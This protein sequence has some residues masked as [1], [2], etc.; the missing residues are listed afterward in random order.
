MRSNT[1]TSQ[2]SRTRTQTR[3][4]N[5]SQSRYRTPIA[6]AILNDQRVAKSQLRL[7]GYVQ[8]MFHFE[9]NKIK[10]CIIH[11]IESK[12]DKLQDL[13]EFQF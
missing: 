1:T 13:P 7:N 3:Y 5:R 8:C 4:D 2:F 12:L 6:T 10:Q 11:V 9:N